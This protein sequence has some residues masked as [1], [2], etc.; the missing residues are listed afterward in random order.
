MAKKPA[1][2][3][4]GKS[5][6]RASND[7]RIGDKVSVEMSWGSGPVKTRRLKIIEID[8]VVLADSGG[9]TAVAPVSALTRISP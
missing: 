7:F 9:R 8:R 6:R 4:V 5:S 1:K 2:K 3:K